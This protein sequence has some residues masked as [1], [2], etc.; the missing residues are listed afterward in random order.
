[1]WFCSRAHRFTLSCRDN[2]NWSLSTY[3]VLEEL[4]PFLITQDR[5][6]QIQGLL[7]STKEGASLRS[8]RCHQKIAIDGIEWIPQIH[9]EF[10]P[11]E[12]GDLRDSK[13]EVLRGAVSPSDGNGCQEDAQADSTRGGLPWAISDEGKVLSVSGSVGNHGERLRTPCHVPCLI[14]CEEGHRSAILR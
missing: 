14:G 13:D 5:L 6:V 2:V 3:E 1:L 12:V 4:E 7:V 10:S 8:G 11:A 9:L